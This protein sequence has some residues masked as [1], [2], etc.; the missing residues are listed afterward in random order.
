MV[1][2]VSTQILENG[3]RFI[4]TK[5]T[6]LSDATGESGV[7]KLN[8]TSSGPYGVVFQGNTIY[9][10][11]HLA[12]VAVWFSVTGMALRVQWHATSNVDMMVLSQA[13]NWQFLDLGRGGF[14]GL[15]PPTGVTGITG[16]IDFTTAA[17]VA[18]SGYTVILK[19]T[20][21]IPQ[22]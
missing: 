6:S 16:S 4:V 22:S 15:T 17:Q 13:D 12:V 9:P 19:C 14:G 8:A 20:K 21:N 11:I 3:P 2:V 1:D 5:F 10:G 18:N 7:T